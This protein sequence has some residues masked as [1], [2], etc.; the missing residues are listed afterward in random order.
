[1]SHHINIIQVKEYVEIK[2][3]PGNLPVL[4]ISVDKCLCL[5]LT[6]SQPDKQHS[7]S[8][9]TMV[10]CPLFYLDTFA[11]RVDLCYYWQLF[12]ISKLKKNWN[13]HP[14]FITIY[15]SSFYTGNVPI[16]FILP[17]CVRE[18]FCFLF[19]IALRD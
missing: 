12:L 13:I 3:N 18:K 16:H 15:F 10:F 9:A 5:S 14:V 6:L 17:F 19:F 4:Y 11:L 7:L 8:S 1:M 2:K